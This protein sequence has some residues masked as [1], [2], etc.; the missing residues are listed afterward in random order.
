MQTLCSY[1]WNGHDLL[2]FSQ[3]TCATLCYPLS[4]A[5]STREAK[6]REPGIEVE[7]SAS[8][9]VLQ[10]LTSHDPAMSSLAT[11][12]ST[13]IFGQVWMCD[14]YTHLTPPAF[15]CQQVVCGGGGR[16]STFLT[17]QQCLVSPLHLGFQNPS[18][19]CWFWFD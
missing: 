18:L 17:Y 19:E 5:F 16:V 10:Q 11:S 3:G 13:C 4:Q 14:C 7:N 8:T 15:A 6:K 12:R 1:S 9:Q 2:V